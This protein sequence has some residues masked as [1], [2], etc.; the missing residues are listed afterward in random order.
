[1]IVG[2]GRIERQNKENSSGFWIIY[3][4]IRGTDRDNKIICKFT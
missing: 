3:G 4:K 2:G 1:M